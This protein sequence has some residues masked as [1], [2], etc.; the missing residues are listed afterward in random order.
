MPV[1]PRKKS[2]FL[3]SPI[4]L[5]IIS[6]LTIYVLFQLFDV[7]SKKKYTYNLLTESKTYHVSVQQSLREIEERS[8]LI[9]DVRGKEAYLREKEGLL[10]PGEEVYVIVD[11]TKIEATSTPKVEESW[12]RKIIPFY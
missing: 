6:I 8:A 3:S 7:Y 12:L 5:V 11:T 10:L 9:E 1:S 2:S 4:T